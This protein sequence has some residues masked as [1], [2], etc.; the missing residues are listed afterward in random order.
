MHPRYWRVTSNKF[1]ETLI[2]PLGKFKEKPLFPFEYQTPGP[3][4]QDTQCSKLCK[5]FGIVQLLVNIS[6]KQSWII[7]K[8]I[9]KSWRGIFSSHVH[10]EGCL[11]NSKSG[12]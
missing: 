10:I 9:N 1:L 8:A 7:N 3:W 6:L 2:F 11:W 5:L 12:P 4:I